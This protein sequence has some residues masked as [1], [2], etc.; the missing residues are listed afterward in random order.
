MPSATGLKAGSYSA[1][2]AD[3]VVL[4]DGGG[5]CWRAKVWRWAPGKSLASR[6]EIGASEGFTSA[7]DAAG[8]ACDRMRDNGAIV[9]VL[10]ASRSFTLIDVLDF[11]P[12]PESVD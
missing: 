11:V 6:I 2:W 5:G 10:D 1:R 9:L 7:H 3:W 8:W 4:I 12:A